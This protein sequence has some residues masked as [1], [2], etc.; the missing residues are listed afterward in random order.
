MSLRDITVYASDDRPVLVV[1]IKGHKDASRENLERLRRSLASEVHEVKPRFLLLAQRDDLF[2]WDLTSKVGAQPQVA[3]AKSVLRDYAKSVPDPEH[4]LRKDG[5]QM[6]L[7]SWLDDLALGIRKPRADSEADQLL[8]SSGIYQDI[9]QGR[10]E[11]EID[12]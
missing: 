11:A 5:L 7:R 1:E 9:R 6:V 2:L 8:V 3:S 4:S 10:V 12:L